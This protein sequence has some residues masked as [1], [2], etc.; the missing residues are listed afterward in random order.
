MACSDHGRGPAGAEMTLPRDGDRVRLF[1]RRGF[2]WSQR[3]P[4]I[5]HSARQACDTRWAKAA[6]CAPFVR[7]RDSRA[8]APAEPISQVHRL[9]H[10]LIAERC[11]IAS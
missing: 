4:W 3:Y 2:D 1:T 7:F 11:N 5:V 9:I 8:K 6:A 10:D